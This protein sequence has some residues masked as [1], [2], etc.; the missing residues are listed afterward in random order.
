MRNDVLLEFYNKN[1]NGI[2]PFKPD[3]RIRDYLTDMLPYYLRNI[4]VQ[5]MV[6]AGIKIEGGAG[7][8]YS[9]ETEMIIAE[10]ISYLRAEMQMDERDRAV[11]RIKRN[12]AYSQEELDPSLTAN[13]LIKQEIAKPD[14]QRLCFDLDYHNKQLQD[15]ID[16][17]EKYGVSTTISINDDDN[18]VVLRN[19]IK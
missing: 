5:E 6:S 1:Y 4:A 19:R 15:Y 3:G 12:Y 13:D 18:N 17:C 7:G 10:I 9:Q 2:I 8:R 14:F 11:S 16:I